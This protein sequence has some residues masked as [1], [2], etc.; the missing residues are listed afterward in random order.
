[1]L[2]IASYESYQDGQIIFREGDSGDWVYVVESGAVELSKMIGE[3]K[4]VIELLRREGD[5]FGEMAFIANISR[6][7]TA[8]AIGPTSVGIVDRK[9][10]DG[11]LNRLSGSFQSIL[12]A[13]VL[14]LKKTTETIANARVKM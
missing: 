8:Q 12:K 7:A 5:V 10:L 6:T 3:T 11:E 1:M 2:Q 4:V 9:Y 13:L 14:R